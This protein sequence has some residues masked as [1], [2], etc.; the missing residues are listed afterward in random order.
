MF[1]KKRVAVVVLSPSIISSCVTWKYIVF[2]LYTKD[3]AIICSHIEETRCENTILDDPLIRKAT[4]L[5]HLPQFFSL[6]IFGKCTRWNRLLC[7]ARV[8]MRPLYIFCNKNFLQKY[9]IHTFLCSSYLRLWEST[10]KKYRIQKNIIAKEMNTMSLKH[11]WL[12]RDNKQ[13][14]QR[15]HK[16]LLTR[17][18]KLATCL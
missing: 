9:S 17:A 4:K 8:A 18:G 14:V 13:Q 2:D 5:F 11:G 16:W 7:S 6:C 10:S 3:S 15:R 1:L 12:R